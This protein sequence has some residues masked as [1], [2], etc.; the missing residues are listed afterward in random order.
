[1]HSNAEALLKEFSSRYPSLS[2]CAADMIKAFETLCAC[3]RNGGKALICCVISRYAYRKKQPT[4]SMNC[5]F[6]CTTR[7]A[8]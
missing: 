3:Y 7:S 1:M 6:P 8:A 4:E 5:T 2:G